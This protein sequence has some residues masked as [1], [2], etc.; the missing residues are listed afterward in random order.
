MFLGRTNRFLTKLTMLTVCPSKS[1]QIDQNAMEYP[2]TTGAAIR[3]IAKALRRG[4]PNTIPSD[5]TYAGG[6]AL[7]Y[8]VSKHVY[9]HAVT[10]DTEGGQQKNLKTLIDKKYMNAVELGWKKAPQ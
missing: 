10:F 3:T 4:S 5:G 9:I 1:D 6:A 7:E 2:K 8:Q